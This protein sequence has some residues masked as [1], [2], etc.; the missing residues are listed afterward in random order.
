MVELRETGKETKAEAAAASSLEGQNMLRIR[1]IQALEASAEAAKRAADALGAQGDYLSPAP[2]ALQL[3]TIVEPTNIIR[4][5]HIL[6]IILP[7]P[8]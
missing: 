7:P 4:Q 2:S 3:G 8:S 5:R 1:E 6:N